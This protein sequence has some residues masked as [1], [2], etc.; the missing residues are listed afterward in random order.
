MVMFR[1]DRKFSKS[2]TI[3]HYVEDY[4]EK[5][6]IHAPDPLTSPE[7]VWYIVHFSQSSSCL[8]GVI[9]RLLSTTPVK[10]RLLGDVILKLTCAVFSHLVRMS[11]FGCLKIDVDTNEV[12]VKLALTA[13]EIKREVSSLI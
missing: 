5:F 1:S 13:S 7:V 12:L 10:N 2:G 11:D 3:T 4:L 8:T 9:H 6:A